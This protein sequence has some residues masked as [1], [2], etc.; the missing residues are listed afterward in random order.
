MGVTTRLS[1]AFLLCDLLRREPAHF[2][3][4]LDNSLCWK[5]GFLYI[6]SGAIER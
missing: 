4:E 1:L 3:L 6:R 5:N 2:V